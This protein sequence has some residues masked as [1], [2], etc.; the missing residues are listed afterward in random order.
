MKTRNII[1]KFSKSTKAEKQKIK[2]R[3]K[4]KKSRKNL[5]KQKL[6]LQKYIY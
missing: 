1:P 5:G 3:K 2:K 4:G 6:K